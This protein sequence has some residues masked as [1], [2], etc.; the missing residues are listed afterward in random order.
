MDTDL[1]ITDTD[2]DLIIPDDGV[3]D[4]LRLI[5]DEA[6]QEIEKDLPADIFPTITSV[7]SLHP[8]V[9]QFNDFFDTSALL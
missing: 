6:M 4:G 3:N 1:D 9:D 5:D 2:L 7:T 8:S